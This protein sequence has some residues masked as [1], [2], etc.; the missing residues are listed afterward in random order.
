MA[1]ANPK[2]RAERRSA[3]GMLDVTLD[4][5]ASEEPPMGRHEAEEMAAWQEDG[6]RN[7]YIE[8]VTRRRPIR[9]PSL[10][11]EIKATVKRR[12]S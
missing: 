3:T 12:G 11:F 6:I 2:G 7:G 10:P 8:N 1:K 9:W 5:I 4:Y